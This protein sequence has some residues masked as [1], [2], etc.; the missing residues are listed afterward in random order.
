M[1]GRRRVNVIAFCDLFWQFGWFLVSPCP[2]LL[3]LLSSTTVW[4]VVS[5]SRRCLSLS[6]KNRTTLMMVMRKL[7]QHVRW[8]Y[9]LFSLMGYFRWYLQQ[10]S[11]SQCT[12]RRTLRLLM[13]LA[14]L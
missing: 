3:S 2:P 8:I 5:R 12:E 1:L 9:R 6:T 7:P 13:A 11:V 14:A 10:Q 4:R